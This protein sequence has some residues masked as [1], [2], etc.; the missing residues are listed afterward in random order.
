M[1]D[2]VIYELHVGTFTTEGT[3]EAVIPRLAELKDLGITAIELLPVAQFP[4]SRNWGY[5]GTFLFAAQN[6][7]GGPEGLKK[8]VNA[9]HRS[10]IAVILDVVY[11]HFGPEG[12][13][14]QEFGPYFTGH[15]KTPW[16]KAINFS[17]EYSD[18]V[19]NFYVRN[20][21]Y[22]ITAC[23][24]DALRL[25]AAQNIIDL[26]PKHILFEIAEKTRR[27][28]RVLGRSCYM[29]AE[30]DLNDP[31]LVQEKERGGYGLSA[32]WSDDFHHCLHSLL[33]GE[34]VAYYSDYG[35]C[36]RMAKAFREGFVYSWEYSPFRKRH[37]G[38]SSA[39]LPPERLVVFSQN[40]DQI[41]NRADGM[42]LSGMI[43]FEPLKLAAAAVILS[44]FLPMLFMGEEY[45]EKNPFLYF[46]SHANPD[47]NTAIREG[48]KNEFKSFNWETEPR[49]PAQ[50]ESFSLSRLKWESRDSGAH[51]VM[52]GY[53]KELLS[54]RKRFLP[55]TAR[56]KVRVRELFEE[57]ALVIEY[58]GVVC[59]FNFGPFPA[60]LVM[61]VPR[62]M[63]EIF[64]SAAPEWEGK[65]KSL[66][67]YLD[68]G[69][70]RVVVSAFNA[71]MY[72]DYN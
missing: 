49:D 11:N 56:E 48:R 55:K 10:G 32:Q 58:E 70:N 9:C 65:G 7:Y 4:G 47:L 60:A 38:A 64:D 46:T 61:R 50:E 35:T 2:Y 30:S 51:R 39:G 53:Y 57:C 17:G 25:D 14:M 21:A 45:A 1:S 67:A 63:K 23:H 69:N 62:R 28:C 59:L 40:H 66:P 34:R 16:G 22:W 52:L 36:A 54:L 42:R 15:F 18:E 26:Q 8:L 37:Y 24:I 41:G 19:R 29:I 27:M 12:S 72:V 33:T 6:S 31:K 44:P 20:A 13:V 5:D 68:A 3:F 43:P 71:A